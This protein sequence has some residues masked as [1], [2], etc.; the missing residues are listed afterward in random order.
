LVGVLLIAFFLPTVKAGAGTD[1]RAWDG[2]TSGA[3]E[4]R[5]RAADGTRL[6]GHRFGGGR[7]AVVLAHQ[8][9][10]D[11]CQWVSYAR[12]LARLHYS[13]FVFDLRGHGQSQSGGSASLRYGGDV[14]AALT[15]V[16]QLGAKKVFLLGA[17]LGGAAVLDAG[18]N[19]RPRVAGVV[20]VSGAADL[21]PDAIAAARRLSAPVLFIAGALDVDFATD[22][23]RMFDA[24]ASKDKQ[25]EIIAGAGEH[26]TQLVDTRRVARG[27]I[28]RFF[29]SH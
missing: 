23:R 29:R 8:S 25:L 10:G 24:A 22:A 18:A 9:E 19:V 14:A 13:A 4:L 28:E 17:S 27:L 26:G 1:G 6:V 15:L 16:R 20:C 2:C 11:L 3:G 5:F 12:R 21:T 7:T